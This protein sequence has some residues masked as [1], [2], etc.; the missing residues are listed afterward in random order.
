MRTGLLGLSLLLIACGA[1]KV[2]LAV[3][4]KEGSPTRA[5]ELR[6]RTPDTL[7]RSPGLVLGELQ[8]VPVGAKRSRKDTV[9]RADH[10][11]RVR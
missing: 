3:S 9:T 4:P 2:P 5:D 7:S 1:S 6:M 8:P 11:S 10:R